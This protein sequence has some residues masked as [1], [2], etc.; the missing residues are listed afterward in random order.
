M[1]DWAVARRGGCNGPDWGGTA[2][3]L[4]GRAR[5]TASWHDA[6]GR[7]I[8]T[9]SYRTFALG[10]TGVRRTLIEIL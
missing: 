6:L 3:N 10:E 8:D 2:T 7:T 9:V 4:K 1:T 5:I